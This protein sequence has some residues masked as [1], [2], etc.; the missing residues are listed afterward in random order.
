[1]FEAWRASVAGGVLPSASVVDGVLVLLGCLLLIIPG[2]I[3]DAASIPLLIPVLRRPVGSWLMR[4][5][6]RAIQRGTLHVAQQTRWG[7]AARQPAA[8]PTSVIDVEGEEVLPSETPKQL[9]PD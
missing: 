6:E 9:E 1:M 5:V 3:T 8:A 4:R 7:A 2:L